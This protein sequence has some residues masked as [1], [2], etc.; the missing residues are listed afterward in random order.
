MKICTICGNMISPHPMHRDIGDICA[1]CKNEM[2]APFGLTFDLDPTTDHGRPKLKG[3]HMIVTK[4]PEQKEIE[5]RRK[6]RRTA[7]W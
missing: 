4:S 5:Q 1:D 6:N 3:K 7:G 2:F